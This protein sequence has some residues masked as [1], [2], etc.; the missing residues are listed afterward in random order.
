MIYYQLTAPVSPKNEEETSS[1][2]IAAEITAVE[3]ET[4]NPN[5]ATPIVE[6][7]TTV[8]KETTNFN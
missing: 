1:I 6:E 2:P 3:K 5:L 8:E 4:T 7:I